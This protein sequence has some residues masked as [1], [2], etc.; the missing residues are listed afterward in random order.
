MSCRAFAWHAENVSV[1]SITVHD[2]TVAS[3]CRMVWLLSHSTHAHSAAPDVAKASRP[4]RVSIANSDV[5]LIVPSPFRSGTIPLPG[6]YGSPGNR[7]KG[8]SRPLEAAPSGSTSP[9]P[10]VS[11]FDGLR[12]RLA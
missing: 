1:A 8:M 12:P 7:P 11:P 4:Q 9:A 3:L 2:L 6:C 5:L 10:I